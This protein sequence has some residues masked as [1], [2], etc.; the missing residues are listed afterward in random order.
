MAKSMGKASFKAMEQKLHSLGYEFCRVNSKQWNVYARCGFPDVVLNP[1]IAERDAR[2]LVK[3]LDR[4]HGVNQ[5]VNKRNAQAIK[6]RQ[7][8]ERIRIKAEID[9]IDA[10]RADLIR[11][12]QLLPT[13]DLDS[14]SRS[15]RM[16]IEREIQRIE[17]ERRDWVNM[18]TK[19]EQAS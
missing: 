7:R 19:L 4:L 9:R 8:L 6:D 5:D 10:E 16:A 17:K 3:K 13:G 11:R 14:V 18:M 12:K 2:F 15:E 1:S